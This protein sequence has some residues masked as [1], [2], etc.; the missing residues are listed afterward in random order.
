MCT[1]TLYK[2]TLK[3]IDFYSSGTVNHQRNYVSL[4]VCFAAICLVHVSV[5]AT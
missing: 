3:P 1:L 2:V 5:W 4:G